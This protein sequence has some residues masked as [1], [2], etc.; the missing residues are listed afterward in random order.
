MAREPRDIVA[1]TG[2]TGSAVYVSGSG[3]TT[4]VHTDS[5]FAGYTLQQI[6]QA[7]DEQGILS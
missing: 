7:L 2:G 5:T 4:D 6:T 1:T 3:T